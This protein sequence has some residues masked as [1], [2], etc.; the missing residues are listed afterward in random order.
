MFYIFYTLGV[1]FV[2]LA[3]ISRAVS[4]ISIARFKKKHGCQPVH[5]VA[6]FERIIGYGL[7]KIQRDAL[8]KKQLLEVGQKRYEENGYTWS[9][10]IM[11]QTFIHTI[12][13]ENIKSVLSSKFND[14]G[15]GGRFK[16]FEPL[17]GQGIFTSD[18]PQ[19]KQ[20]RVRKR[21]KY[22]KI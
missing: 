8:E 13:P 16:A 1:I 7:Y 18:G 2:S 17:Q 12:D 14:F 4:R 20:A 10:S 19:W 15:V 11:G 6:Q 9:F 5:R 22:E 21:R 3:I